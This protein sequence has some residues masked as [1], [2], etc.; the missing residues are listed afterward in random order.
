[1]LKKH[2][3][4]NCFVLHRC[5]VKG[6]EGGRPFFSPP[7]RFVFSETL[8]PCF[9]KRRARSLCDPGDDLLSNGS[10]YESFVLRAARESQ[11]PGV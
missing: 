8:K 5:C 3:Q 4:L 7:G 10:G 1:M 6:R 2:D 11:A 9:L